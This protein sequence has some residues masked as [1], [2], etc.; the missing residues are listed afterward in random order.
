M[1][2]RPQSAEVREHLIVPSMASG[3]GSTHVPPQRE[4]IWVC[5]HLKCIFHTLAVVTQQVGPAWEND[6]RLYTVCNLQFGHITKSC[7]NLP[8]NLCQF[9]NN[10]QNHLYLHAS[11]LEWLICGSL[12][13]SLAGSFL[14]LWAVEMLYFLMTACSAT[15]FTFQHLHLHKAGYIFDV[16]EASETL[17][18][19]TQ[20]LVL[21][22]NTGFMD[23]N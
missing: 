6:N 12:L 7:A 18:K 13:R 14:P 17:R 21:F 20:K 11:W 2:Q 1:A 15:A 10:S 3:Q 23:R 9:P 22:T 8:L 19:D 5:S 16:S 4:P